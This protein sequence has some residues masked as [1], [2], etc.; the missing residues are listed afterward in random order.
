[1]QPI[2]EL[3]QDQATFKAEVTDG[4]NPCY[5]RHYAGEDMLTFED[6]QKGHVKWEMRLFRHLRPGLDSD[7]W[8]ERRNALPVLSK[9]SDFFPVVEKVAKTTLSL[10]ETVQKAEQRQDLKT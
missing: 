5:K 3:R 9:T 7:D 6:L 1:M 8:S 2:V 4:D 10:V